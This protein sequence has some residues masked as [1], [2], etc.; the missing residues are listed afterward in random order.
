MS[1]FTLSS[2]ATAEPMDWE[3]LSAD[4]RS[5]YYLA[6]G[7]HEPA[8]FL[9]DLEAWRPEYAD[10]YAEPEDVK[11]GFWCVAGQSPHDGPTYMECAKGNPEAREATWVFIDE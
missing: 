11:H 8:A 2:E 3:V 10:E 5:I 4:E 1:D 9:A 7:H 6:W